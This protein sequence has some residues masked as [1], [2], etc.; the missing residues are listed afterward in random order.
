M[1]YPHSVCGAGL[2][3]VAQTVRLPGRRVHLAVRRYSE[4]PSID[5]LA[6]DFRQS[7][8]RHVT[9]VSLRNGFSAFSPFSALSAGSCPLALAGSGK[10]LA[11]GY[12]LH[13]SHLRW[14]C[15][16]HYCGAPDVGGSQVPHEPVS[17]GD[18]LKMRSK[19]NNGL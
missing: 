15:R 7:S 2:A 6:L 16:M 13:P 14:G 10:P 11:Q 1:P 5:R 18:F 17:K 9:R 4:R 12:P 3:E 19:K 8:F